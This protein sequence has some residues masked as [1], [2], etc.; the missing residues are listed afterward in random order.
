MTAF[1]DTKL[2]ILQR[3]VHKVKD[4]EITERRFDP[5]MYLPAM[6]NNIDMIQ[7]QLTDEKYQP[8]DLKV[9]KTI[10]CLYF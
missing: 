7:L 3:F 4:E 5:V 2:Q 8:L 10:V 9:S 1:G 6:T